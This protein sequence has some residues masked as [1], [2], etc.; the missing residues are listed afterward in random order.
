MIPVIINNRNRL[1]TTKNMVDKLLSLDQDTKIHILD[2][3][4]TY[5]PLLAWYESLTTDKKY[6]NTLV[7]KMENHGH[8]ALWSSGF[9][10]QLGEFFIYTDSD[11]ILNDNFPPYYAI[12]MRNLI[13]V[14][15]INK[16]GL[17]LRIDDLPD[18]YLFKHQVIRN[19][20]RWWLNHYNSSPN[21]YYAD[22][23]TTF[24]MYR[25]TGDNTYKSLRIAGDFTAKHAP[26]YHNL[27][28]LDEEETYY[29]ANLGERQLTQ[30]SKQHKN[31]E[32]Y[33]DR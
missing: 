3:A 31:P 5:P 27:D 24:A 6:E 32:L 23:D 19:E 21:I 2:N 12:V 8:L 14:S 25:N 11:I 13:E 33:A 26:W 28:Q 29:L 16:I 4:S 7:H 22:T 15:E 30:Y 10:K 18:H 17:A 1:T 20:I 9:Y